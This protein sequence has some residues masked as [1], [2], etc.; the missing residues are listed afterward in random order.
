M[1]V[2]VSGW[3]LARAVAAAG[4][5][6]VVSGTALDVQLARRLQLGD[7]GGDLRRSLARFPYRGARRPGHEALL[8]AGRHRPRRALRRGR[9]STLKPSRELLGLN[10]LAGFV[11]VDLAREGHDGP[12]GINLLQKIVLPTLPTL[13]GA[14]LAGVGYVL[15]GAGIPLEIPA[16]LDGALRAPAGSA[17]GPRRA[18]DETADVRIGFDPAAARPRSA[19]ASPALATPYF[20]PIIS[21]VSL[22]QI[23][24]KRATGP[25]RRVR[26]RRRRPPAATMRRRAVR[27]A[28]TPRRAALRAARRRRPR[29][30]P[31]ARPAV[32]A[33]RQPRPAGRLAEARPSART[34]SRSAPRSPSAASRV[35]I[36]RCAARSLARVED[37]AAGCAPTRAPPDRLPVQGRRA[38]RARS[39]KTAVYAHASV[40]ATSAS[41]A[42]PIA[43]TTAR[44]LPLRR[45]A[46]RGVRCQGRR[47]RADTCGRSAFATACWPTVGLAEPQIHGGPEPP[48]AHRRR[49]PRSR[50]PLRCAGRRRLRRRT[51]PRGPDATHLTPAPA[52]LRG[53]SGAAGSPRSTTSGATGPPPTR[54]SCNPPRSR[55]RRSPRL[56]EARSRGRS[57]SARRGRWRPTDRAG[58]PP[59]PSV[60]LSS[61]SASM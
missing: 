14:M 42:A 19:G 3:R 18:G 29:E 54:P 47:R 53:C 9:P 44:R 55:L 7:L 38:R 5:L 17:L 24:L 39:R 51:G 56:R 37:G 22:A 41:C 28:S 57:R 32:L 50:P 16:A 48:L 23:L 49:R 36:R 30:A 46:G 59:V 61:R 20:F 15:M 25:G 45:R 40:S 60:T 6:G 10:V 4:A 27:R 34:A 35:S 58:P 26:R 33:R 21:S 43:A 31:R 1:G 13:Y 8:R 11:E 2:G 52:S 12:V